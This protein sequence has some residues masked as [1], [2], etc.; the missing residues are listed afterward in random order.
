MNKKIIKFFLIVLILISFNKTKVKASNETITHLIFNKT[1]FEI[2]EEIKL[3]INLENFYN[4]NETKIII[5]CNNNIFVPIKKNDNY[6]QLT[7]NSIYSKAI[8]NEYVNGGYIRFQLN[9]DDLNSGFSSG[10][11]NNVG[12]FYFE[13][14]KKIDNIYNYF[15]S[16][17]F[18][19]VETGINV[20]L[21]DIYNQPI[22][23]SI[24]YS[25]K[26]KLSWNK[27]KYILEVYDEIPYF[28]D[29]I[30]VTNRQITEYEIGFSE[31][32]NNAIL[33]SQIITITVFDYV[34]K[35]YFSMSKVIDI[36]DT[37]PPIIT[38]ENDLNINDNEI[39][40][41]NLNN[42]YN[43]VDNYDL[44]PLV[45]VKYYDSDNTEINNYDLFVEYLKHHL[46]GKII[47]KASDESKN[48]SDDFIINICISDITA[49]QITILSD[50]E[51]NDV[52]VS[53]FDFERLIN[54][55]DDYDSNPK[56]LIKIY[57]E[58]LEISDYKKELEQGNSLI[59]KYYG[60]D[61]SNNK[62]KEI[63]V[64]VKIKDTTIPNIYGPTS[65]IINDDEI[66]HYDFLKEISITDNLDNNP[67]VIMKY[68]IDTEEKT[69]DEWIELIS[70]GYLGYIGYYGIDKSSNKTDEIKWEIIVCDNSAPVIKI[71]NIK[72][73]NKYLKI[74]KI[75][76]EIIDNFIDE[77]TT[78]LLLNDVPYN[79]EKIT[80]V[81]DYTLIVK[82]TDKAG[83]V[84]EKKVSFKII[85]NNVIGC[86]DDLDCYL[87]NYLVVVI[88]VTILMILILTIVVIKVC[89]WRIKK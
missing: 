10:Y 73:G 41:F 6:G 2:G 18:E 52:D 37:T 50:L 29:D 5:K 74:E 32:I 75:E 21:I 27:E 86:G 26:I 33:G 24:R 25:E 23:N 84:S 49:P 62:T 70:R 20:S 64:Q 55:S 39:E 68:Y 1:S 28:L 13:S 78:I 4:L 17:N 71:H 67:K 14:R 46:K 82:A 7:S 59:F 57:K 19:T 61:N 8:V 47:I 65:T 87:D 12:E 22:N 36:V 81:G 43:V 31:N 83:N 56:V 69:Y 76:Y 66:R 88:I 80:E 11:K 89:V 34:N 51:I 9:K 54:I 58:N 48:M 44:L 35:D 77:V 40:E 15:T 30:E 60:I 53:S 79:N 16:S 63:V 38:G 85:E 72:D 42:Y 45:T 3:T